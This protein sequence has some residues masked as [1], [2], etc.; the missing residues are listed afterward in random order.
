MTA[1][2]AVTPAATVGAAPLTWNPMAEFSA[3]NGNP[4]GVW[5]YGWMDPGFTTFTALVNKRSVPGGYSSWYGWAGDETPSVGI[6]GGTTAINGVPPGYLLLHPGNGA[7]PSVLRWTAP[8]TATVRVVGQFQAGDGG[9]MQVAVRHNNTVRFS[10]TDAGAF[11]LTVSVTAGDTL[12]F[13]VF[14]GYAFGSTGLQVTLAATTFSLPL[15]TGESGKIS[16]G[17][18]V[19]GS[20]VS[21]AV[22]GTGD[23]ADARWSVNPDGSL[24]APA[25][26]PWAFANSG[27]AYP[28]V[29]G[30][31]AGD[32]VNRFAGGG[33]NYDYDGV[34]WPFAGKQTTDTTDSG[35]IRFG[36]V[37][38][39]FVPNPGRSDW[40]F[41]G[42]GRPV[43][44]PA[45][46]GTLYVAVNATFSGN[47]HGAYAVTAS[48][49]APA[50]D[51]FA[52]AVV[53]TGPSHSFAGANV[54]A[55]KDSGE[56]NH[57]GNVGGASVWWKWT[58]PKTGVVTVDTVGSRFDTLLAV[59]T[60]TAV[61]ALTTVASDDNSGPATTS[62]LTFG[63]IAGTT[64]P[65]AVDGSGGA[66]GAI[67]L[68]LGY[69]YH[70]STFAGLAG[71]AGSTDA[72]GSAARFSG[73]NDVVVDGNG[74]VY[75][76]ESVGHTIRKITAAGVVSTLAGS[77]GVAGTADG[78]G[79]AARFKQPL[80]LALDGG[81]NVLVA[82]HE[83][84]AIRKV[85]P[86]GVVTTVAGLA[87]TAGTDN[88]TGAAARFNF[89]VGL[90]VDPAGNLFVADS[91]NHVIRKIAAGG[92]VTTFAGTMG[93]AGSAD[94]TGTAAK[95]NTPYRLAFDLNGNLFVSDT[96]NHT[97]R[98]ITPA[99]VVTTLAGA[100]G[101][102]GG[103]DGAGGAARFDTPYGVAVDAGGNVFTA[104]YTG[105][106]L[107]RI[108]P[109][110]VVTT[111]GGVAGT[112]GVLDGSG[113]NARFYRPTGVALDSGGHLF[114]ADFS[115]QTIRKGA[116][117][118]APEVASVSPATFAAGSS[119]TVTGAN[120]TAATA[121]AFNGVA[122]AS[123]T[124]VSPTRMTAVA[125]ATLAAGHLAI[126]G[127][128]G[129]STVT[130]PFAVGAAGSTFAADADGWSLVSFTN[131][132][133]NTY[134]VAG[135]YTATFNATGGNSGG[136]ISS[137]DPDG[138][139]F[140]F[141]APAAY[142]GNRTS[143]IGATL[144]YDLIHPVGA[145]D[146]QAADVI[147][148]G[149]GVR[150]VWQGNPALA[151]AAASWTGVSVPL[152][153]SAQWHVG[154]TDGA[155]ATPTDFQTVLGNLTGLYLRGE[156]TNGADTTGLDNVVL[157]LAGTSLPAISRISPSPAFA[158]ATVTLT[159]SGFTGATAVSF[160]GTVATSFTVVSD[161]SLTAVVPPGATAGN[162]T[163]TSPGGTSTTTVPFSVAAP[164]PTAD[165]RFD[166]GANDTVLSAVVQPDGRMV[167]SGLFTTLQPFGSAAPVARQRI[168]RLN[169]DGTL[170]FAFLA[171]AGLDGAATSLALQSDGK[172]LL[173]GSFGT[174]NGVTRRN[175]ARL[176]ADG[177]LDAA[178]DPAPSGP[179][180]AIVVRP[181]G[182]IVIGGEFSA[183]QPNGAASPTA[184]RFV[185]RLNPEGTLDA[186][187]NLTFDSGE[188]ARV[189]ALALQPGGALLVGG[190]FAAV[191]GS[192]RVCFARITPA[193]TLD[194]AFDAGVSPGGAVTRVVPLVDGR[195]LLAGSFSRIGNQTRSGLAVVGAAGVL[196]AFDPAPNFAVND[197]VVQPDGR[198]VV[199][200]TFSTLAGG[201]RHGL[202]RLRPDGTLDAGFV[203]DANNGVRQ[204]ALQPDGSIVVVGDF[205]TLGG[206]GRNRIARVLPDGTV[207][208]ALIADVTANVVGAVAVQPDG[209]LI[210][211]GHFTSVAGTAR[212]FAARLNADSTLDAGFNPAPDAS[213][214][215]P[216]VLPNGQFLLGGRFTAIGGQPYRGVARF[217]AD[218][219]IDPSFNP[220]MS[221]GIVNSVLL[222]PDGKFVVGGT[223]TGAG[224][225]A[226]NRLARYTADG[227]IDSGFN[228]DVNGEV[229]GLALQPDGAIVFSGS[230]TQVGGQT[231]NRLARVSAA[232]VLDAAFN[233]DAD[234]P[235]SLIVVQPDGKIVVSGTFA[236][237]AGTARAG[238]ARLTATGAIDA[239]FNPA[240][241]GVT[242][243]YLAQA[244]G[245]LLATGSFTPANGLA[246]GSTARLN[247]DGSIDPTFSPAVNGQSGAFAI[248]PDGKII[249]GG[250]FTTVGNLPRVRLA[251]LTSTGPTET[252]L[253]ATLSTVTL[254]RNGPLPELAWVT[255]EKS[256]DGATGW[257]PLGT[258]SRVGTT[259]HWQLT[260]QTLP[261]NTLFY[262]RARAAA[263]SGVYGASS[264]VE[265]VQQAYLAVAVP[266]PTVASLTP[267]AVVAGT[268]VT[269]TGT[270][271]SGATLVR[272]NGVAAA[273]RVVS[274][275]SLTATVPF[276][277]SSGAVT[278]A[279]PGGTSAA[280]V[281]YT[282]TAT[283]VA[284]TLY[285]AT[286]Q[287]PSAQLYTVNPATAAA[288]LV[289]DITLGGSVLTITGLAFHP[290]TGVLYGVTGN[291]NGPAGKLV[292]IDRT[293]GLATLV[294]S[295][296][297]NGETAAGASDISFDANGTLY[298]WKTGGGPLGLV[299]VGTAAVTPIGSSLNGTGGNGLAFAPDGS[300]YVAGP[301]TGSLSRVDPATGALT[302]VATLSGAPLALGNLNAMASDLA[303]VLFAVGNGDG[304]LITLNPATG[305]ITTVGTLPFSSADALAFLIAMPAPTITAPPVAT[306][307]TAGAP[308]SLTVLATGTGPLTYQWQRNGADLPGATA[309]TYTVPSASQANVGLYRVSV[310]NAGG[311]IFSAAVPFDVVTRDLINVYARATVA[312][313]GSLASSFTVEGTQPKTVLLLG[314]GGTR[315]A[316]AGFSGTGGNTEIPL[317]AGVVPAPTGLADPRL[318]LTDA[319]GTQL[320]LNQD[321]GTA[322]N[323]AA[324]T[325]AAAQVAATPGLTAAGEGAQD[326]AILLTLAP[327]T[328]H[329]KLDGADGGGGAALLQVYDADT[330]GRPRLV[331]FTLRATVGAGDQVVTVGFTLDGTLEKNVL[332]RAL[333]ESLGFSLGVLADPVIMLY[334]GSSFVVRNDDSYFSEAGLP[335]AF[336]QVGAR[337][338][339][340]TLDS[341][342]V[343]TVTPGVYTVQIL[344]YS[345]GDSG[346]VLFEL[347]AADPQR[348]ATLGPVITYLAADQIG[349]Q[350]QSVEFGVVAVAKPAATYQW[351]RD[352]V[353]LPNAT[354]PV[355]RLDNIQPT[356]IANYDVVITSGTASVTSPAR[357]LKLLP[358]FHS[359][360]SDRDRRIGLIELTRIIQFYNQRIG[361]VRTGE[362]HT[363][364]G[365]EDGFT[366]G[367]GAIITPHAADSNRDGRID[368]LELTRVIE[369]YNF[370]NGSVR[371]GSYH[372]AV[373]TEDGFAPGVGVNQADRPPSL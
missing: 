345:S 83:N 318:T 355:L 211:G 54:G 266:A 267:T 21:L 280:T 216:V 79:P 259:A 27:A 43:T 356:D 348:A 263:P 265:Q 106:T 206:H 212:N 34:A 353:P 364:A 58:A 130:A 313:L 107:R 80:G 156:Y 276:G 368:I 135:T 299:D 298:A 285:V 220:A 366:L 359:A 354:H 247:A 201:T 55:G 4:N 40:F 301:P 248:Q 303:G 161:L 291:E 143:S 96:F 108:T 102:A 262:L 272:F 234:G 324:L 256:A 279:G 302:A 235:V 271:F 338:T 149:N 184:R 65:I 281:T 120:F 131:L 371:T 297:V 241:V 137:N 8:V 335:A 346:T 134:T 73:P 37:V 48:A 41:I 361:T 74:N 100:V 39:T 44:V 117:A 30:F 193:D 141:A 112:F 38:G 173:G 181:D 208:R 317:L 358:E 261:A 86:A 239:A 310:S 223:F 140:T 249:L 254:M 337:P 230:F 115:N 69:A 157:G 363:L 116:P 343:S 151:P 257:T 95:F 122:A 190:T 252:K 322:A 47:N 60:G 72:A 172:I 59:Y 88:A 339:G 82:D 287:G 195:M 196:G 75:V 209:K 89:P 99:G 63:A 200:G 250:D 104:D 305:A 113:A 12:N 9:A 210:L 205:T 2:T 367:P 320:A 214:V 6:N 293:T 236:N 92:V 169:R 192:G 170:D 66:T 132:S 217:N 347:F 182:K 284:Q 242:G 175:L 33:A 98:K 304:S 148:V 270:G 295:L 312:P 245:K 42:T 289:G 328:Y 133:T 224:G 231:R 49:V 308:A 365:T 171:T 232:G 268:N 251:R 198:I 221:G 306:A 273:F 7:E 24:A 52:G 370:M 32:G 228:P 125:P 188:S 185:A 147:L 269:L 334:R 11:D 45:G 64:Y 163:V 179:V 77:A 126:T 35:T 307:V 139:D 16:L 97:I 142:L 189:T 373:G 57:A 258:A 183:V 84:H 154:T 105:H 203:A 286:G 25:S 50:N 176:N 20:S 178:F 111:L 180:N 316:A 124:V 119:V 246:A 327:G 129:T 194:P 46:G 329:V 351:R 15:T 218:G 167:I 31:P 56:I 292:T 283:P 315:A 118:Y 325:A 233:P 146:Y 23:L 199:G 357:T 162:V 164:A 22:T 174:V 323:L 3:E 255:F 110:G 237:I 166:P 191:N 36:A 204:L 222:Q 109:A 62:K 144:T 372:A 67:V 264:L 85:T 219:S 294:G 278:V 227:S 349:L 344:P 138:G 243:L 244:D 14:G 177:S 369:L 103:V 19:G 150:L 314:V 260:G 326:A 152:T 29:A 225:V 277:V 215:A 94:G 76:G 28:A 90:T 155:L 336:T 78:T 13:A 311:S 128:G 290:L 352:G 159:G 333:G 360:D 213:V 70:F 331:M 341:T 229:F 71:S 123:F 51:A 309:A 226:R 81:G 240:T 362:Y 197:V 340:G 93:T 153:P 145:L 274:A 26:A 61:N 18:L 202:A 186:A 207:E 288:T 238:V 300:L 296:A 114:I 187:L 321:W 168:A 10:A 275:T 350:G 53:L 319:S 160:N 121:V 101:V 136:Y 17:P 1:L 330:D 342:L 68:N 5:S 87:G 332:I 91:A 127:P 158:G 282:A 253:S 165:D